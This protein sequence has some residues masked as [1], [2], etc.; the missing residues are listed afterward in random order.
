MMDLATEKRKRLGKDRPTSV[1]AGAAGF[2]GSHLGELLLKRGHTVIGID[3]LF[4]GSVDNLA[5]LAGNRHLRFVHQDV[6]AFLFLDV[7]VYYVSHFATPCLPLV[8][9]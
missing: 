7:P 3:K 6:S 9:L 4:T 5:H 1:V 8:Y 2:L